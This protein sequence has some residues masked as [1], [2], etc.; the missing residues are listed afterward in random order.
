MKKDHKKNLLRLESQEVLLEIKFILDIV[1]IYK[2]E[3]LFYN[4]KP[5]IDIGIVFFT[6]K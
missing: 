3:L 1:L 4:Q 2:S 6:E 5:I